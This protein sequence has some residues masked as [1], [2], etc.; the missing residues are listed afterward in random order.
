MR[1]V[2]QVDVADPLEG[3]PR[4]VERWVALIGNPNTGKTTLFNAMTGVWARTGNYPGVTVDKRVATLR[5]ENGLASAP[6]RVLDLPGTYS[7]SARSPDEMVAVDVLLG[8]RADTPRP[9][10]VIV[11][12][13]ATNVERNLYLVTQ[14]MELGIPT[15]V[16]LNMV[17]TARSRD[18]HVD[19][20]G[21][22]RGLGVPVVATVGHRG[23]GVPELVRSLLGAL[24]RPAPT[25][26]WIWPE[27]LVDAE[28]R[29]KEDLTGLGISDLV[30]VEIRRALLDVDGEAERRLL[31]RSGAPAKDAL[32]A[33]RHVLEEA[34]ASA[35]GLEAAV[36]YGF[37]G[38]VV[39]GCLRRPDEPP[40]TLSDRI[41]AV[42]THGVIGTLVLVLVLGTVFLS[43]FAWAAPLMDLIDGTV[44]GGLASAADGWTWLGDGALKS[45]VI[46]GVIAGVGSVLV[47]LPQILILFAFVALLEGCGYMA[48]AAILTDRLM[49]WC[50]LS[51]RSIIP[52]LSS[53]ACAVPGI[54][55]TRTIG[56][57]RDRFVTILVAPLMSCSA[58]IPVYVILT[59]AFVP[60]TM[61]LG[62]LPLQGL[63]FT[64]MYF[65]GIGVAIP[66]AWLLKRTLLQGDRP[67]FLVELPPYRVPNLVVVVRRMLEQGKEFVVRAGTLIFAA[68][69]LIWALSYFPRPEESAEQVRAEAV[70][71]AS[72]H[73]TSMREELAGLELER[74]RQEQATLAAEGQSPAL[75]AKA[76]ALYDTLLA[77]HA[78]RRT[79][80]EAEQEDLDL[81]VRNAAG[82]HELRNSYL[83]RAGRFLEP[84]FE[85]MG[86]DWRVSVA[87]LASFPAREVVIS[88]LGVVYNLGGD[89]DEQTEGLRHKLKTARWD[90]GPQAGEPV[91]DLAGAL[92]LMVFF[93]LCAQCVSTLVTIRKETAAWRW[94]FFSFAY[95]T[96][97]AYLGA[98]VT[99]TVARWLL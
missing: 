27:P 38:G 80:L 95:M 87:V 25:P 68:T 73:A 43:I 6:V 32:D 72:A 44:F 76:R 69:I 85:P 75:G 70:A 40:P 15:V 53:F 74:A 29:L 24:D 65:V 20:A 9:A 79:E 19:A 47:F 1:G 11:V 98:I 78:G 13:D 35:A 36:R 14:V 42:L 92:A 81:A 86:W 56:N 77:E 21:L 96:T 57:R 18:I 12:V 51:G 84:A 39:A 54:M 48:R 33:A 90:H 59:A 61:V 41:D 88:T 93:A 2:R 52:M 99:A 60:A 67:S 8:R 50:G 5:V 17:D 3:P 94:A 4:T 71:A 31:A 49:R 16:A 83:G 37:I 28:A 58:R 34:G 10:G 46:D 45:L 63:V 55:S 22:A 30:A 66:T 82:A 97:I 62:F 23:D 89:V 26:P 91:F 64:A 7:L